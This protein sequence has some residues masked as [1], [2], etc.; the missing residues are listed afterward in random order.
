MR[1]TL[2]EPL[3]WLYPDSVVPGT[4]LEVF[5]C[6][7]AT[8]GVA[9]VNILLNDLEPSKPLS[10]GAV[11][12]PSGEW[13]R[14]VD[15]PVERN[16]GPDWG[17]VEQEGGPRNETVTRRAPFRV[18]DA[19]EPLR[20]KSFVP[21][22]ASPTVALRFRVVVD[23]G[24]AEKGT[25][26]L[27]VKQGAAK[28]TF[29][30]RYNRYRVVLPE[31][32][33]ERIP[34]TNW[35]NFDN[36][37]IRHGLEPWGEKYWRMVG[38]YAKLMAYGRQNSILLP[39]AILFTMENGRPV[40]ER[41]RLER[42]VRIFTE[43]G[44][45]YIEGGHFGKRT[46]GVWE[47]TTFSTRIGDLP[48][49]TSE[50]GVI[51]ASIGR[52]LMEAIE[53]NGWQD[54]WIQHVADEPTPANAVD[55]RILC[56]IVRR[57]MPGVP[58]MDATQDPTM[59]GSVDIW[60]P[61]VNQ[62]EEHRDAFETAR[63]AC[64]DEVWFYT[65]CCPGGNWLNRLL[66][67]ELLRP[68]LLGW[69]GGL[70]DLGGFLHWG[71]NSYHAEQ[72]PFETSCESRWNAGGTVLPAGDTHIAYPGPE[73]PWPG[74]RLEAMRQGMEDFELIR[75]ARYL[76]EDDDIRALLEPVIRSFHDYTKD[77][78]VY[79]AIR[80]RLLEVASMAH[81]ELMALSDDE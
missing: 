47:A 30:L 29:E 78:A 66:D 28:T 54:R 64:G 45:Y 59:V 56:G 65:C 35:C 48:A 81:D 72:N 33:D 60:C 50:G 41:R 46:G 73:G 21:A 76:V 52:Q 15:V 6:D 7:V 31:N 11:G 75:L 16:T 70:Y 62:Y 10:F 24:M 32:G 77:V 8:G 3:N 57:H 67:L 18:Y 27:F 20:R 51:V 19:M 4:P 61:L 55:Y 39:Q 9:E 34:Y 43:A 12:W 63:E 2:S 79:R 14:L 13:F 5:E 71:F 42:L 40:L 53:E 58:L 74:I 37:A 68:V 22:P 44:I 1:S 25:I 23:G 26:P 80:R 17:F 69:G 38:R 36:I 49:T